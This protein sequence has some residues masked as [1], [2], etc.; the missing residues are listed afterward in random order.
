MLAETPL[1]PALGALEAVTLGELTTVASLQTR[2]DQ[3]Y[4]VPVTT[5]VDVIGQLGRAVRTLELDD[6]RAFRYESVYFDTPELGSFFD[7]AHGRPRRSK[8][9]TR[10]YLDSG[11]CAI[12]VK[13][14]DR[15]GE[16]VKHRHP[17]PIER[18][19]ELTPEACRFIVDVDP[20]GV[21]P[22][23]LAPTLTTAYRRATLLIADESRTTVDIGLR[24]TTADGRTIGL[25]ETA[26]VETKS[27]TGSTPVDRLL[28]RHGHRPTGISKYCVGM[29]ALHPHLPANRWHRVLRRHFDWTPARVPTG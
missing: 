1:D 14:R 6:L 13:A 4:I 18:R 28:W 17:H 3:K 12:E 26:L 24:C 25:T 11:A 10:S 7:A 22:A 29:A 2:R 19:R 21:D 5:V 15:G 16:T 27:A 8:I 20:T 9:R 23:Q